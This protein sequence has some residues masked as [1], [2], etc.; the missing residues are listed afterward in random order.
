[1]LR[2]NAKLFCLLGVIA[3]VCL[4]LL[5][6]QAQTVTSG[7]IRGYVYEF[8]TRAPIVGATVMVTNRD[9]GLIR[10]ALTDTSGEYFIKVLP[11]GFY[12]LNGSKPDYE[13]VPTSTTNISVRILD[14]S[15]VTPPPIE[16][17]KIASLAGTP[18]QP[19]PVQP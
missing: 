19:A 7:A 18:T 13:T 15:I 11:V 2:I 17:R 16:L 5:E 6:A 9:T 14:P 12:T 8:G 4:T 10:S 1:M 3:F